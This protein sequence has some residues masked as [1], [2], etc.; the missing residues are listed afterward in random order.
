MTPIRR[1]TKRGGIDLGGTK[2]QAIVVD[3]DNEVIGQ[4]RSPTPHEGGPDAVAAAME[5]AIE[6]SPDPAA[7]ERLSAWTR[8][9]YSLTAIAGRVVAESLAAAAP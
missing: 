2:I 6:A 9:R 7:R 5:A 8:D 1:S 4:S 3:A